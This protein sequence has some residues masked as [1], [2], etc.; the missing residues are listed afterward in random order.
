MVWLSDLIIRLIFM[1]GCPRK[2]GCSSGEKG[3]ESHAKV[4]LSGEF[5]QWW[6]TRECGMI[7]PASLELT[8]ALSLALLCR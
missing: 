5:L 6:A 1:N 2:S 8:A 4:S 3:G 7:H